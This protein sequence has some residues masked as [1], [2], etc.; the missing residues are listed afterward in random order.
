[1]KPRITVQFIHKNFSDGKFNPS[2]GGVRLKRRIIREQQ[3]ISLYAMDRGRVNNL[4]FPPF[5]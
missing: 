5:I 4:A 2:L 1:M 3:A